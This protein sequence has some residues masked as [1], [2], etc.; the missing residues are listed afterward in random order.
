M[1]LSV[2]IPCFNAADTIAVQLE[3]LAN[4]YWSEPWEVIVSDN[5]STDETVAIAKQYQEKMPHLQIVDSS[6]QQG[7]AHARNVGA[8]AAVGEA[9]AFCDADDELAPGW[10]A[11]MGKALAKYDFI[12]CQR[13][14]KKLNE[15]WTLKYRRRAQLAQLTG[16]QEYSYPPY[17]PYA[18]SSTLGVRRSVHEAIGGFDETMLKLQDTDYCWKIQLAG[19]ELHF[20]PEAVVHYRFRHTIKGLYQQM[21]L[22]GEYNVLLYKKYRSLGMPKL[23]PKEGVKAWLRLL[24]HLPQLF[25]KE[26]RA[27]WVRTLAWRTGRLQGCIKY[28]VLAL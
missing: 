1:K 23:S 8:L 26:E 24:K 5:G 11:A 28:R 21:R 22:W 10:V 6:D 13:E 18:S 12:A 15:P 4:Q 3:A 20:V 25:S 9:F 7:A 19:T 2:I 17:L 14:Y 27:L 16:L